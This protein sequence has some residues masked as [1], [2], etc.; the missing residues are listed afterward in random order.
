M[1]EETKTTLTGY[2]IAVIGMSGRFPG[3]GNIAQYWNNL[4]EGVESIT[5]F[6]EEELR[7]AGVKDDQ[8]EDPD[9]VRARA[10]IHGKENFDAPFFDYTAHEAEIMDPQQR[11]FHECTWNALE[12]AGYV[13][14]KSNEHIGMYA[15]AANS[16]QW[17]TAMTI[18]KKT[19]ALGAWLS[20]LYTDKDYLTRRISYKLNLLGPSYTLHTAC[21]T[22][23]VAV[24]TAAQ[25]VLNGECDIALAGGVC[26]N[27][28]G[29]T[30]YL[31]EEGMITSPDGTCRAFDA[32]AAG[33]VAG[34]G[35]G[36]VVLKRFEEAVEDGDHI[37]AVIKGSAINNDG[38]RK[39]GFTA[40]GIDGQAEVIRTAQQLAEVEPETISYIEAHGTGTRLGDPVEMEALNMAFETDQKQYCAVG[41]V[42]TNIGHLDTAAGIAGFIKTVLALKHKQIPPSL[43]YKKPNPKI[44]FQNSPFYINTQ[45][46]EWKNETYPLRAGISSFG[47]GGTNAHVI[48]EEAPPPR[49]TAPGRESLLFTLSAKTATALENITVNLREYLEAH[50]EINPADVAYTLQQGREVFSHRRVFTGKNDVPD[51]LEALANPTS[52]RIKTLTSLLDTKNIVFMFPGQGAQY[53]NMARGIYESEKIFREEMDR[54]FNILKPIMD[55]DLKTIVYPEK[56]QGVA[57]KGKELEQTQITQPVIFCIEYALA[58]QLNHWGIKPNTMM[59]H[60]IGE[61]TAACLAGLFSLEDALRLVA[62]RGKLMQLVPAGS[63]LSVPLPEK[64]IMPYLDETLSLAAVNGPQASVVS[65]EDEAIDALEKELTEKSI[66][67]RRLHTSHAFHSAMMNP[68]LEEFEKAVGKVTFKQPQHP[69]ISNVTGKPADLEEVSTP[70]YWSRHLRGTVRFADGAGELLKNKRSLFIEV[71]PGKAL[72][73]FVRQHQAKEKNHKIFNLLRHPRELETGTDIGYLMEKLGELW[74]NAVLPD[75]PQFYENQQ[76]QRVSLPGYPFDKIAFTAEA[77]PM[78]LAEEMGKKKDLTRKKNTADW[79]YT[80]SRKRTLLLPGDK[81]KTT[82]AR[83]VFTQNG[84]IPA[85]L[86]RTIEEKNNDVIRVSRGEEYAEQ[87]ATAY[88]VN[89]QKPD[90]FKQLFKSLKEKGPISHILHLWNIAPPVDEPLTKERLQEAQDTG[91]YTLL[92]IAKAAGENFSTQELR[93]DVVTANMQDV[94]GTEILCPEKATIPAA[95]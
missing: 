63:M 49:D 69:F 55:S 3:A 52:G 5:F 23:L 46:K 82:G 57:D 30:G 54:C 17:E 73:T 90:D 45:L 43:H 34:E 51:I 1:N 44:D 14:S 92:N 20:S 87:S 65:G 22:S 26:V 70:G 71:G 6:T 74:L 31:Y 10:I 8:L 33:T 61:Y 21:S 91:Y 11:L 68:I 36:I 38:L 12:D 24:H 76:R 42:K 32:E 9:Y 15:G 28:P 72:S 83:V 2:E 94:N 56:K 67:T 35:V 62:L 48:L 89:P 37:Y 13:P 27:Y 47:I 19:K 29:K 39:V 64:E 41:S 60:S 86:L 58:K 66:N 84:D 53:V 59:G 16:L 18:S 88:R 85:E 78:K 95:L 25:A 80:P 93:I 4:R 40:P 81:E 77:D 50:N 75:W 7:E 79:F